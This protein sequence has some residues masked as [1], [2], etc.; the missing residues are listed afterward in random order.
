MAIMDEVLADLAAEGDDLDRLVSRIARDR[1]QLATP[2]PGWTI[3]HQIGHLASSDRLA[4]LAVTD[5]E[6]FRARQAGLAD[7]FDAAV[8]AGAAEFVADPPEEL[9]SRWR[10]ARSGERTA[11]VT[12][13]RADASMSRM[14]RK[15]PDV[16]IR[17]PLAQ[18]F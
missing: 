5:A 6:A 13:A 9:L 4:M 10:E 16:P 17:G 18:V 7:D 15:L 1:W 11:G 3:A 12:A 14:I 8:E 2:A